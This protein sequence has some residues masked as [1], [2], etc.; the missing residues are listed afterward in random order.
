NGIGKIMSSVGKPLLMDNMTKER[1]LK[2]AANVDGGS[3]QNVVDDDGKNNSGKKNPV[4]EIKK[5]SLVEKPVLAFSYNQ[6]FRPKVLVRGSGSAV[7]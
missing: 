6:N 4:Q 5:K 2:K 3:L 7:A 1:C